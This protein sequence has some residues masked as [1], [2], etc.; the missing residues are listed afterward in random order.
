VDFLSVNLALRVTYARL[1]MFGWKIGVN[2]KKERAE[3]D[4]GEGG[5]LWGTLPQTSSCGLGSDG[6]VLA[7]LLECTRRWVPLN[8]RDGSDAKKSR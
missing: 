6:N 2:G 8:R 3:S 4:L 5:R 1:G 7:W